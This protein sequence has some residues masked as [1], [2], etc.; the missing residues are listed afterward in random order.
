MSLRSTSALNLKVQMTMWWPCW[1]AV[2]DTVLNAELVAVARR[3][4]GRG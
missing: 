1:G 2:E 4:S 3:P